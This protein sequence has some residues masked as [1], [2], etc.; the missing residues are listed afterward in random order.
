MNAPQFV[1]IGEA[2]IDLVDQGRS[3]Y[4]A[5]A[6]G[7]PLNVA[8]GL[9]R[10]GNATAFVGRLSRDPIGTLLRDH[11]IHSNLDLRFAVEAVEPSTIA[12][13]RLHD[14]TARYEFAIDGTA[15][16]QWRDAE[17]AILPAGASIVHFGSLASWLMPGAA[18]VNRL[19]SRLHADGEVLISYD[20]NVRPTLQPNARAARAQIERAV[21]TAHLVKASED[22]IRWLYDDADPGEIGARWTG[23]GPALVVIT[24]GSEGA[25]ALSPGRPPLARPVHSLPVVDTVGAGDA[26]ASGLLAGLARRG[27]T[28]PLALGIATQDAAVIAS[29]LEEAAVVAAITC[30]R[31]GASLP[32]A[33]ELSAAMSRG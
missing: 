16:F 13:A 17:L 23:F 21:A 12:L 25:M 7:S 18:A 27:I 8:I 2:L 5:H 32:W 15:D 9:S 1:V 33:E 22:D 31:A 24:R 19:A 26:F 3:P 28:S 6:G 10:L 30:S 20:P 4:A 11:A 29:L 14:G